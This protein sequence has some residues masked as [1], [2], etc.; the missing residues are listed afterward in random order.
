MWFAFG[1]ITLICFAVYFGY[2]RFQHRLTASPT[3]LEQSQRY[4]Q[5]QLLETKNGVRGLLLGIPAP[6][7]PNYTL[8][9][10]SWIDRL[11]KAIGLSV[12]YQ[13]GEPEFDKLVYI[14]SDDHHVHRAVATNALISRNTKTLFGLGKGMDCTPKELHH[15]H[16][17]L[18]IR[19]AT[20]KRP[21]PGQL[22]ALARQV[23]PA[24][25]GIAGELRQIPHHAT[26]GWRDP[27][28]L[29]AAVILGLS[30]ALAINATVHMMRIIWSE[31]PFTVDQDLLI[32]DAIG[33]GLG[34][35]A[36][37][38]MVTLLVLG[39]SARTHLVLIELVLVGSLGAM[40]SA[41]FEL[42]ELNME[43]DT[44]SANRYQVQVLN[45][46]IKKSRRSTSHYLDVVDWNTPEQV[47][48]V[49]VSKRLYDAVSIHG[50]VIVTQRQGHLGYRW[51]Q[52]LQQDVVGGSVGPLP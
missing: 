1:F 31:V 50:H 45:K 28:V 26:G 40:G 46:H 32:A 51:V 12:E 7:G 6:E 11:C 52:D 38:V 22:Q 29:K 36:V 3:P 49:K 39:R 2:Q 47:T 19:Y 5:Y 16:G 8:K 9:R 35:I 13:I 20:N 41:L 42:R 34:A 21:E 15:R 33:W 24:L 48:S 25:E 18:W 23:V 27:F 30:T 43:F 44:S 4:F 37:L 14:V 10:E 17:M